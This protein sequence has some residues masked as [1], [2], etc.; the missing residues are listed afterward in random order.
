M[1]GHL[2]LSYPCLMDEVMYGGRCQRQVTLYEHVLMHMCTLVSSL[3]HRHFATLERLLMQHLL[4]GQTWPALLASDVL[5]FIARY[6]A[7][8]NG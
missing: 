4:S 8:G 3:H 2:S 6:V 1:S 7:T 5:C